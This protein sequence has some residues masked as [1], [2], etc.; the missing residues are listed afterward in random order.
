MLAAFPLLT[1]DRSGTPRSFQVS[2]EYDGSS[3]GTVYFK[4]LEDGADP[5][6]IEGFDVTLIEG[7]DGALRIDAV[8]G[9]QTHR[10]AGIPDSLLP[11]LSRQLGKRILSSSNRDSAESRNDEAEKMWKRLVEKGLARYD[12]QADRYSCP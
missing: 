2:V 5:W 4:V 9:H 3:S 12:E 6:K 1:T 11:E 8:W 7:E 10:A